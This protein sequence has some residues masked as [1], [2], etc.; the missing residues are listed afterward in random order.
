MTK[1]LLLAAML[2]GMFGVTGSAVAQSSNTPK[3]HCGADQMMEQVMQNDPEYAR[4]IKRHQ[5]L[6]KSMNTS[7][8]MQ[9]VNSSTYTVPVVVHIMHTYGTENIT[10]G[11]VL[12]ALKI[13]N[14]DFN[15]LNADTNDVVA[16]FSSR[17]AKVGIEFKLAKL[18][19]NGNPTNGI[20]RV[21]TT[22]THAA[23]DNMK[24][25]PEADWDR[26]KYLN[27]WVVKSIASGAGGYSFRPCLSS[28]SAYREGVVVLYT[29]FGDTL[30]SRG[31][32]AARTLTHEVG[33]YLGLPHTWG[34]SNTPGL[35]SNC[36]ID[37]DITDTPNTMGTAN[38]SCNTNQ[39]TCG[40][41][42]PGDEVDNVQNYMDY[43]NCAK[44]FTE[45]QKL[46][47][48]DRLMNA[49]C[50]SNLWKANNLTATGT[51]SGFVAQAGV[52]KADFNP[53]NN[54][55]CDG[56][57]VTFNN[58]TFNTDLSTVT[59]QWSFPGGT[60]AS[61][62]SMNPTVVYSTPGRYSATLTA[63]NTTGQQSITK[64][65]IL[66]VKSSTTGEQSPMRYGFENSTFPAHGSDPYKDW[67][68]IAN[69]TVSWERTGASSTEGN[70][71]VRIR[72][73]HTD[74]GAVNEL[75]SPTIVT[76]NITNA[77][78]K[79]KYAYTQKDATTNDGLKVYISNNCGASWILRKSMAGSSMS[80]TNNQYQ[81]TMFVPNNV[82][83]R[84]ETVTLSP[85]ANA[86]KILVK[87]E[88]TSENGNALYLDDIR[89]E[90]IVT[91]V[92]DE[93]NLATYLNVYPNPSDGSATISYELLRNSNVKLEVYNI[94]GQRIGGV[95]SESAAAGKHEVN[96]KELAD[97]K[98]GMY[99]V[100]LFVDGQVYIK[101][102]LVY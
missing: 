101:K 99:L 62:T 53:N 26:N 13:L 17:Y 94:A 66:V 57:S 72:N 71:A 52:P 5:A 3:P 81:A 80:T 54:L 90:G 73:Q 11:Q 97:V 49:S 86:G 87:F 88:S 68:V 21:Y 8:T 60:P 69:G 18:D 61:S 56:S 64:T 65:D 47:M 14:K 67:T 79:F 25:I 16:P 100:K 45:G 92:N 10:D 29:Q 84:E 82:Q 63:T 32:F 77:L 83:W 76:S 41:G 15:K 95:A 33:H 96:L 30:T 78:L 31:N 23:S 1:K 2:S 93:M 43:S 58:H 22:Q 9:K 44:M 38:Q 34:G 4:E 42:S 28:S 20:N 75:I 37:D 7:T 102:A 24:L 89:I 46:V 39:N 91:G 35:G 98:S 55:V 70:Y 6:I 36:G 19:P 59:F 85:F 74:A 27:I 40:A 51:S 50:R 12:N 48:I